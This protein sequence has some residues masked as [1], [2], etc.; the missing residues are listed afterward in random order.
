VEQEGSFSFKKHCCRNFLE[1]LLNKTSNSTH[2]ITHL[3]LQCT[4]NC[5]L[6][7]GLHA[8]LLSNLYHAH[9]IFPKDWNIY[10]TRFIWFWYVVHIVFVLQKMGIDLLSIFTF[11][12]MNK[13]HARPSILVFFF[14]FTLLQFFTFW[15]CH[16]YSSIWHLTLQ[17]F[18]NLLP[19]SSCWTTEA[20]PTCR[21]FEDQYIFVCLNYLA[22]HPPLIDIWSFSIFYLYISVCVS[23]TRSHK[24][25]F[26]IFW[27]I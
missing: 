4:Q 24:E 5:Q 19:F 14:G 13:S 11:T 15:I 3:C 1:L 12:L 20:G 23:V 2:D 9:P 21:W 8:S 10:F 7:F 18:F 22:S 27:T 16:Y 17:L 6:Y 25:M 26:K